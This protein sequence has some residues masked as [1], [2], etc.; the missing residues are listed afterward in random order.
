MVAII[1]T[2]AAEA[3]SRECVASIARAIVRTNSVGAGV[4]T[5]ISTFTTF[6]DF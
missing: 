4:L 5:E 2:Y 6:I 3:V 1:L